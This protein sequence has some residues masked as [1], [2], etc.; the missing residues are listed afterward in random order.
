M[1]Q[2]QLQREASGGVSAREEYDMEEEQLSNS[3]TGI[4]GNEFG[5][6]EFQLEDLTFNINSNAN[7]E[8]VMATFLASSMA[9]T[10]IVPN[11]NLGPNLFHT[12]EAKEIFGKE[13][14][15]LSIHDDP[16]DHFNGMIFEYTLS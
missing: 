16:E 9:V 14:K 8:E 10:P 1:K 6:H 3:L 2:D 5:D 4:S 11:E 13:S 12:R 15:Q 7:T